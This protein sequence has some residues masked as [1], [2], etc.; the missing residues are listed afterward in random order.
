MEGKD[1]YSPVQS[2]ESQGSKTNNINIKCNSI[3]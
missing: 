3:F 2:T 1:L